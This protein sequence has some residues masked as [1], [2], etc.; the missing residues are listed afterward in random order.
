[1]NTLV[2]IIGHDDDDSS[3]YMVFERLNT[4]GTIL[5]PQKI[6]AY[7]YYG[8]FNELLN[9]LTQNEYWKVLSEKPFQFKSA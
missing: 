1:M 8:A 5:Q 2:Q 6:R 9:E 3:I 4:G 7:V